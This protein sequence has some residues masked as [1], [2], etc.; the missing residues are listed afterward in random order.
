MGEPVPTIGWGTLTLE[1]AAGNITCRNAAASNMTNVEEGGKVVPKSEVVMFSTYECKASGGECVAPA[2]E[3][4]YCGLPWGREPEPR[5]SYGNW[6]SIS[7]EEAPLKS[8]IFRSEAEPEPANQV[9]VGI[10]CYLAGEKIGSVEFV[11]GGPEKRHFGTEVA[12][13]NQRHETERI[14]VRRK[15]RP[16]AGGSNR[17]KS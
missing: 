3:R 15:I 1:S 8:G 16:P 9:K 2:E 17:R 10:E 12:E 13:R 7:A 11:T 14:G 5:M 6:P 4:G